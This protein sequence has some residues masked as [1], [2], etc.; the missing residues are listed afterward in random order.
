MAGAI[1][2][3]A[4]ADQQLWRHRG[5]PGVLDRG[6]WAFCRH[7]NYLGEIGFWWGLA[8]TARA[9]P[10][11]AVAITALFL[12]VSIPLIEERHRS[13]RPDYAAYQG[14]VPRLLPRL[15]RRPPMG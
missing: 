6:L 11:G 13:R 12:G 1:L 9:W 3:E 15:A 7:P 14:R 4:A 8:I 5:T 2:L 10:I